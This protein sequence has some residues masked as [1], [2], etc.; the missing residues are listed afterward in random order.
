MSVAEIAVLP[1]PRP[2]RTKP[3]VESAVLG[4]L[5]FVYT[6][7]MFFAAMLSG[8]HIDQARSIT[9]VWPPPGEPALPAAATA[10][11]TVALIASGVAV[12]LAGRRFR[13]SSA[14]A[15]LPL[16][17]AAVL[18]SLFVGWQVYEAVKLVG[19]GLTLQTS[20]HSG[21]F[22]M[23]VGSHAVH[24]VVAIGILAWTLARIGR[25]ALSAPAFQA[26]RIFWYFVVGLW[27]FLYGVVYL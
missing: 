13:E 25:G 16:R 1:V 7:V 10:V 4:M 11:T 2:R 20:A 8:Y 24:C 15:L 18:A 17:I 22:Y 6:E 5:I 9:G 14:A 3:V 27:P 21:F 26:V 23:I 12:F 19:E